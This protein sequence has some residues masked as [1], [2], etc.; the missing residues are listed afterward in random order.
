MKTNILFACLILML[1]S[2]DTHAAATGTTTE[3]VATTAATANATEPAQETLLGWAWG[4]VKSAAPEEA[5]AIEE[6]GS[7]AVA[8]AASLGK[9]VGASAA[10]LVKETV[11]G[12]AAGA[13]DPDVVAAVQETGAAAREVVKALVADTTREAAA[14]VKSFLPARPAPA[15]APPPPPTVWEQRYRAF[16]RYGALACPIALGAAAIVWGVWTQLPSHPVTKI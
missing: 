9:D 13:R 2:Y 5:K 12:L 4:F 6:T 8:D 11:G 14:L 15:P 3:P 1:S 7:S 16:E 10:S